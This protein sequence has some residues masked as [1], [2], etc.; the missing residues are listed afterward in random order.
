MTSE[1][2]I[3]SGAARWLKDLNKD[4]DGEEHERLHDEAEKTRAD[5]LYAVDRDAKPYDRL[6]LCAFLFA[7]W[8]GGIAS[9]FVLW[10]LW[11]AH[12]LNC[13]T[14]FLALMVFFYL[15]PPPS[16]E[17]RVKIINWINRVGPKAF[18]QISY[19]AEERVD[20]TKIERGEEPIMFA[21]HP[22]GMFC[23]GFF[24]H[25]GLHPLYCKNGRV[26]LQ[27]LVADGL[28]KSPPFYWIWNKM[29]GV[30][31]SASKD[32]MRSKMAKRESFGLLPGGFE[33]ATISARGKDRVYLKKRQ[34]FIKYGLEFGYKLVPVY[35]FGESDTYYNPPGLYGLRLWLNA[36]GVPTVLPWGEW[37]CPILPRFNTQ[38]HSV[39][40]K[41]IALPRI[42]KPTTA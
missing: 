2:P 29:L 26:V 37:W 15:G 41:P 11:A 42:P 19:H 32:N 30:V 6:L 23:W 25:G 36:Y 8:L 22:H 4:L 40:A 13:F 12:W 39:A 17:L 5:E 14:L 33:E 10:F 34:G 20:L 31:G 24:L 38:V 18:K 28:F 1:S 9:P 7:P 16:E 27:G 21:Y 3:S 35:T